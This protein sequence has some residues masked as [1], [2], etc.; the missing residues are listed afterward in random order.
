MKIYAINGGPRKKHNT[1]QL[2]QAA[3]D[4]AAAAPCGEAVETEMINLYDL[5]DLRV[6]TYFQNFTTGY[7]HGLTWPLLIKYFGNESFVNYNILHVSMPKVLRLSEQYLIRAEAYVQRDQPDYGKAGSDISVLRTA[8][9]ASYGG[10]TAMNKENA[11]DVIEQERVKELY[12]EGDR[13]YE[14]KRNGCPEW[15]VISNGLKYT[16]REYLY[17]SPISK[18]D[19]DD[20]F[21]LIAKRDDVAGADFFRPHRAGLAVDG[22]FAVLNEGLGLTAGLGGAGKLQQGVETDKFGVNFNFFGHGHPPYF[23]R[24]GRII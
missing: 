7:S 5:N 23:S 13:W 19:V 20:L 24:T 14:L 21:R 12:M 11:M 10:S 1:A 16:T 9:Y 22:Y 18:S 6:S 2:L 15:W 8:R 17:T 3:L 4:G